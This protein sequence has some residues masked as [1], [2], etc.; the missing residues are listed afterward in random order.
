MINKNTGKSQRI[1]LH[2]RL[3]RTAYPLHLQKKVFA[4]SLKLS[5]DKCL[6]Y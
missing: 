4:A 6:K 2:L 5:V 3:P 1:R